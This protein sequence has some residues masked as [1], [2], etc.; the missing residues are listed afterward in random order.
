MDHAGCEVY[1]LFHWEVRMLLRLLTAAVLLCAVQTFAQE[2]ASNAAPAADQFR[3]SPYPQLNFDQSNLP[4]D[5]IKAQS[6]SRN[7]LLNLLD[8]E[9]N[10]PHYIPREQMNTDATC[11][12]I[13]SYLVVPD[14]PHSDSTHFKGSTTCVPGDRFKIYTTDLKR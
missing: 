9:R 8:A 2:N 14:Y 13:V 5:A 12:S 3:I 7:E 4:D 11:F 10:A 1:D 6:Q